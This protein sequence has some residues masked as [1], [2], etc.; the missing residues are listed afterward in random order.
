MGITDF[1]CR[2][3]E[4]PR[5]LEPLCM[6]SSR[7]EGSFNGASGSEDPHCQSTVLTHYKA[8]LGVSVRGCG[9]GR[10]LL[11]GRPLSDRYPGGC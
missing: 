10:V 3:I 7:D 5:S 9:E 8:D 2:A 11:S 6:A 4:Q 1:S